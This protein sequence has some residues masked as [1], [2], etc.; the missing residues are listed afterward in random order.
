MKGM[1]ALQKTADLSYS[2]EIP[3]SVYN[4]S[5][6]YGLKVMGRYVPEYPQLVTPPP[7]SLPEAGPPRSEGEE[8][9]E[10]RPPQDGPHPHLRQVHGRALA[11]LLAAALS[12]Y[13]NLLPPS[14]KQ[15]Y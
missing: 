7:H 15:I 1:E 5:G 9:G 11:G 12:Q 10:A 13:C 14:I 2:N 6:M 4:P 3:T 8:D